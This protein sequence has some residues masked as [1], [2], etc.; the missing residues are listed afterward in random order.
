MQEKIKINS[1][2]EFYNKQLRMEFVQNIKESSNDIY[3]RLFDLKEKPELDVLNI[4]EDL[5]PYEIIGKF[6]NFLKIE[7]LSVFKRCY[8]FEDFLD[9]FVIDFDKIKKKNQYFQF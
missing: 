3:K 7:L 9:K 1:K 6:E 4:N 5:D 8:S 2:E